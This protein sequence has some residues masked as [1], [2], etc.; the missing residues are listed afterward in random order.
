MSLRR[1]YKAG[2]G[3]RRP[4]SVNGAGAAMAEGTISLRAH[5]L[6]CVLGVR[7]V[8][9]PSRRRKHGPDSASDTTSHA[10]LK[11][12]RSKGLREERRLMAERKK[13][14]DT[15]TIPNPLRAK[16][17]TAGERKQKE[18]TDPMD[19][20]A[21]GNRAGRRRCEDARNSLLTGHRTRSEFSCCQC[22]FQV[23]RIGWWVV[24][25]RKPVD[26]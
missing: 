10:V 25:S 19:T 24:R 1:G 22:K 9:G 5:S 18:E 21:E 6:R 11:S 3:Q 16:E 26:P 8:A 2:R 7:R 12:F 23:S 4:Q 15:A 17:P 20:R 14:A 13:E